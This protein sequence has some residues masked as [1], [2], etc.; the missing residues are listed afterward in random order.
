MKFL[1]ILVVSMFSS[2]IFA[3]GGDTLYEFIDVPEGTTMTG[4]ITIMNDTAQPITGGTSYLIGVLTNRNYGISIGT[5]ACQGVLLAPNQSCTIDFNY[6]PT[7]STGKKVRDYFRMNFIRSN[8]SQFRHNV[9]IR[10]TKTVG[11]SENLVVDK[12][13]LDF[14]NIALVGNTF[15]RTMSLTITN[16]GGTASASGITYTTDDSFGVYEVSNGCGGPIAPGASCRILVSAKPNNWEHAT[17]GGYVRSLTLSGLGMG[18]TNATIALAVEIVSLPTPLNRYNIAIERV[19][20]LTHKYLVTS[21]DGTAETLDPSNAANTNAH[22]FLI[23]ENGFDPVS[24]C[25]VDSQPGLTAS[26]K[27]CGVVVRFSPKGSPAVYEINVVHP[28]NNGP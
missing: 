26:D 18:T 22:N 10:A 3:L 17:S 24:Y 8:G 21:G 9:A 19:E 15:R 28:Y 25:K 13:S 23:T 27:V 12:T 14:G 4:Q 7:S 11:G 6:A 1:A 20:S 5:D 16:E 2:T